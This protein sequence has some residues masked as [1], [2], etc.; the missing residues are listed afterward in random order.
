[1]PYLKTNDINLYYEIHGQ[2]Q[3]LVLING[4]KGGLASWAPVLDKLTQHFQ[5]IIFDNRGIGKTD[6]PAFDYSV[7]MMAD[8]TIALINHLNLEQPH[9]LGYS[10]GGAIAQSIAARYP[11]KINKLMLCNTFAKFDFIPSLIFK[12]VL[13]LYKANVAPG[14]IMK[15]VFPWVFSENFLSKPEMIDV[16][17]ND[18]HEDPFPQ[19]IS[20]YQGQLS[21]LLNFD[22]LSWLN[23]IISS[24]LILASEN[25]LIAPIENSQRLLSGLPN[26]VFSKMPG[27]H[28]SF[29]EETKIFVD[30]VI[31]WFEI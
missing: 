19:T 9:I 28:A 18:H 6:A 7:G 12:N 17:F 24:T 31:K 11:D 2:G 8:D 5:V 20:G 21:A 4:L 29:I 26:A 27:G 22:S 30:E 1:M 14:M 3:P 25:D 16:L 13:S 10:L 15:T 23:K